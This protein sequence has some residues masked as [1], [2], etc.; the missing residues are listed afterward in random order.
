MPRSAGVGDPDGR[1]S[2]W[3]MSLSA[4]R[5]RRGLV[6]DYIGRIEVGGAAGDAHER[7]CCCAGR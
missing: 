4:M 1:G 2:R 7:V 3:E 6:R 5:K